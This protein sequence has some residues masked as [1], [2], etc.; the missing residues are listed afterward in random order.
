MILGY[1]LFYGNESEKKFLFLLYLSK[2]I[3]QA[4]E[5]QVE[6]TLEY[7]HRWTCSEVLGVGGEQVGP[8]EESCKSNHSTPIFPQEIH[9]HPEF[10]SKFR[11][12]V[13]G[14]EQL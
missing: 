14:T 3:S 7:R 4:R 2:K 13:C 8:W 10:S 1:R 12:I 11:K 5:S 9:Y 6:T